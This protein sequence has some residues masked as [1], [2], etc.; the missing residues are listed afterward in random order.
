MFEYV[1]DETGIDGMMRRS[2]Q[3]LRRSK[4]TPITRTRNLSSESTDRPLA[5]AII[6]TLASAVKDSKLRLSEKTELNRS[7]ACSNHGGKRVKPSTMALWYEW[8]G[9]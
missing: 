4:V 2:S 3:E 1:V 8:T 7:N 6:T 9:N 5:L